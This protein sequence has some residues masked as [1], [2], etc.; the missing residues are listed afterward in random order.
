MRAEPEETDA[1]GNAPLVER[2]R[3][4]RAAGAHHQI[5]IVQR[6]HCV[7]DTIMSGVK[8]ANEAAIISV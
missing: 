6:K 1:V 7:I 8:R 5:L 3:V 2:E 4:A